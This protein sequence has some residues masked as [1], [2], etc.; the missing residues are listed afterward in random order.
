[1]TFSNEEQARY[2]RNILIPR[3]GEEGQAR[4]CAARVAVVGLGGLGSPAALYLAAAGVGTL[5]LFDFDRVELSNLQRQ[6]LHTTDRVGTAKAGSAAVT[7][8]ALNPGVTLE[9]V[10]TRITEENAAD[11]LGRYDAVVEATD[12]F[13]SKFLLNDVCLKLRKPFATAGIL[14]LSG[15]AL[16]VVPGQTPC[17]RCA[18]P[19][20]PEG[21]PTTAQLGVLGAVPGILGSIE[22]FE[23]I[24]WLTGLWKAAPEGTGRLHTVDGATLRLR[25][26]TLPAR[27]DC[28]CAALR[29]Q[30]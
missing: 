14:A 20:I 29:G 8:G 1:L 19:E 2:E 7:L 11:L 21:V 3:L 26:L 28:T 9:P 22:A 6:V 16:F 12:N 27:T 18:V 15:Q 17:L 24:R 13:V 10:E 25:T 4:L 30:R 5:G 23:I